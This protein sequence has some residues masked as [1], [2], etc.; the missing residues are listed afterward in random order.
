MS[1]LERQT[2]FVTVAGS[3]GQGTARDGSDVD[4]RGVC[5]APLQERLSLFTKFEQYEGPIPGDLA[6]RLLP[7]L[8]AHP[9]AA[10][11]LDVRA[12]CVIFDVAKLVGLCATANPNALEILFADERDWVLDSAAWR[13]LHDERR[14]FLTK[15]V[16][17]TF[18]GYAMA[19]LHKIETHRSWLLHP[20]AKKPAREAFG[21]PATGTLGR[22]DQN[23]IEEA[24]AAE[25]RGYGIDDIEMPKAAR[26]AVHERMDA[27]LRKALSVSDGDVEGR[28]R[29]VAC[30]ALGLPDDVV[31]ALEGE[32]RYRA[33]M[34]H[35]DAYQTWK[36]HRNRARAALELEHGYDTKHAMHLIRLM[37][38]GL[39]V[40]ERSEL[41][42]RRADAAELAAIRDGA[43]SFD[44]L[45]ATATR[46]REAMERAATTSTLPDDVD[47]VQ[48]DRIALR[49]MT[50][51]S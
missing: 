21:L 32:R 16:Q 38:M 47:R 42:V 3:H 8:E 45:L 6:P 9:T 36:S 5:V 24:V 46:L 19:Q 50:E 37:R 12:E 39:E 13:I 48:V 25:I 22:D 30:R 14:R 41:L 35:W 11:G 7:R 1:P 20:P 23:R 44:D 2:I 34:K 49:L 27:F 4:L 26:I 15:K 17:Q 29:A 31:A 40:L 43:L 10:R 18:L 51:P 33:A 28:V